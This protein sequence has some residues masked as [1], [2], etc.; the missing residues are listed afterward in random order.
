MTVEEWIATFAE[1]CGQPTPD[2]AMVET[3]LELA[4]VAAHAS[5]R[6]AAPVTCW[7]AA[8]AGM[9]PQAALDLARSVATPGS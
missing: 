6:Q 2:P 5:G 8:K 3:I 1:A 7:L 4:G 9:T